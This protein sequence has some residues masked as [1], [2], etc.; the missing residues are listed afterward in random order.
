RRFQY[1]VLWR[2]I[3]ITKECRLTE[4]LTLQIHQVEMFT[5]NAYFFCFIIARLSS[6]IRGNERPP[7]VLLK[8]AHNRGLSYSRGSIKENEHCSSS[9]SSI[10]CP[11]FILSL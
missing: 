7:L 2:P 1:M 4:K 8:V 5:C 10:V 9:G 6:H 3:S 11:L